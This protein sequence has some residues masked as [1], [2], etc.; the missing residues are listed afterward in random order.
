MTSPALPTSNTELDLRVLLNRA[1]QYT[2]GDL[3]RQQV[4]KTPA[5]IA[6]VEND[7]TITYLDF[8]KRVNRLA[9]FL[10]ARGIKRGQRAAILSENRGEYLELCLAAAKIGVIMSALNCRLSTAETL[11]CLQLVKP[12]VIF[13]SPRYKEMYSGLGYSIELIVVFGSDYETHL[14]TSRSHD[15]NVDVELE[16][17]L[18]I[19]Y[20]SGTTGLPKG[21]LISHRAEIARHQLSYLDHDMAP[22]DSFVAWAPMY[23][24]TSTEH[25]LHILGCG[26]KVIIVDGADIEKIVDLAATEPQWWLALLPGM[27][28]PVIAEAKKRHL[29]PA[30]IKR[31]GALADLL[32]PHIIEEATVIFDAPYWNIYGATEMGFLPLSKGTISVGAPSRSVSKR[33]NS[34][35]RYRLVDATDSDVA[36]GSKGELLF[37]GPSLF[38]GYWNALETNIEDMRGGWFH[39]GDVFVE[40]SDG[41]YDFVDR[42]KYLIKSGGEN[43][44]P[45]E[46]ERVLLT[47]IRV[48]EAVVVRR[49]DN[50]WGEVPVAFVVTNDPS[51]T[52][53]ELIARCRS[54][55]AGYKRPKEI[56]FVSSADDFPRS[57]SGKIQRH[58]V[59][60]WL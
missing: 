38:S 4:K 9:N 32:P 44:Y 18:L 27:I 51:L 8:E 19:M 1:S 11:H 12:A 17:G 33:P 7:T 52:A 46:I 53:D 42:A 40:N 48:D 28:E 50:Q 6:I 16:D 21:A 26:G 31:I 47:D 58:K 22:G 55:L 25:A 60:E 34:I 5:A 13:L 37:A 14:A 57:R 24:I 36:V 35:C 39:S 41:S 10:L 15:P 49:R 56:R 45:A 59:E 29:K 43:I 2:V 54:E 3:L 23:H 30:R 20:T